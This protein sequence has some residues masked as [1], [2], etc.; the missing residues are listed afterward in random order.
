MRNITG[1]R[2]RVEDGFERGFASFEDL[3]RA[4]PIGAAG[5]FEND[6]M[7]ANW[8]LQRCGSVAVEFFV[9]IDF[10]AIGIGGDGNCSRAFWLCGLRLRGVC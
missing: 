7:C 4:A 9:D 8:K 2:A 10:G 1:L 5:D 3:Q 6:F